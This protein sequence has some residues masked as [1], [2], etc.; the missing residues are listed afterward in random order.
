MPAKTIAPKKSLKSLAHDAPPERCFWV[1]NGPIVKNVAE[2]TAAVRA[3]SDEQ[4]DYHTKRNGNDF[5]QWIKDVLRNST[6]ASVVVRAKTRT[7][8]LRALS[9]KKV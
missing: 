7:G 6:L 2:L 9:T 1:N 3:M 5:A 8:L 4:F